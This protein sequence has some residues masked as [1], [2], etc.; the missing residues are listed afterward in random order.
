M[1]TIETAQPLT[2]PPMTYAPMTYAPMTLTYDDVF[3]YP[4]L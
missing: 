1:K 3:E 4:G 2:V